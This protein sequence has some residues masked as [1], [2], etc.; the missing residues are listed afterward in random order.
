MADRR[1]RGRAGEGR[2]GGGSEV[3]VSAVG[4]GKKRFAMSGKFIGE[5]VLR[6]NLV[7]ENEV[8]A[9]I[10]HTKHYIRQMID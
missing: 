5:T 8:M 6:Q 9:G 3:D 2:G 4:G 7:L 1:I 10:E